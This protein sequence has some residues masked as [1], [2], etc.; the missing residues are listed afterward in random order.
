LQSRKASSFTRRTLSGPRVASNLV[1]RPPPRQPQ[2]NPPTIGAVK[3]AIRRAH[4]LDAA[5]ASIDE[6]KDALVRMFVGWRKFEPVFDPGI[7]LFR[8]R[9]L[10]DKPHDHISALSYPPAAVTPPGRANRANTPVLYT[11]VHREA[12]LFELGAAVG[13]RVAIVHYE[14]TSPLTVMSIGFTETVAAELQSKRPI[15]SYAL[16]GEAQARATDR[17]VNEYLSE[18]FT[19]AHPEKHYRACIAVAEKLFMSAPVGGLLYPSFAVSANADNIAIKPEWADANLSPIYAE[20]L[21]VTG[22][23]GELQL[24]VEMLDEAREFDDD[25]TIRWLGH[26]GEW[27]VE[28][29]REMLFEAVDGHWVGR[30]ERGTVVRPT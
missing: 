23:A 7:H 8:G 9:V 6:L 25:G 2:L 29:M 24:A 30:D 1:K 22:E 3:A 19:S 14:T 28:S 16:L 10:G 26:R 12:V 27:K 13:D 5:G 20:L 4:E 15:P 11:C 21:E 17:L 18:L